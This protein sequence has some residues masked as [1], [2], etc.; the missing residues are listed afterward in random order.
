M[1]SMQQMKALVAELMYY[2]LSELEIRSI[3]LGAQLRLYQP[4]VEYAIDK[5]LAETQSA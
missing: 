3:L 4:R 2:K 5:V 1:L